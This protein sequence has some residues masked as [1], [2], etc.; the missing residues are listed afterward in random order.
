MPEQELN[1]TPPPSTLAFVGSAVVDHSRGI[2]PAGSVK[3]FDMLPVASL[4][5]VLAAN[6]E[7]A[8]PK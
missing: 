2:S 3:R 7:A 6:V 1:G 5:Q 4:K 8:G